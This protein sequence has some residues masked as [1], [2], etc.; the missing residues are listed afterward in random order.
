M[1]WRN[2]RQFYSEFKKTVVAGIINSAACTN[3]AT[4]ISAQILT[5]AGHQPNFNNASDA[6]SQNGLGY[7]ASLDTAKAKDS[8]RSAMGSYYCATCSSYAKLW[9][10]QLAPC[11]YSPDVLN[12][13]IIP[14]LIQVCIKGSDAA[15]P[16]GATS[17]SPD[18]VYIYKSFT[19]VI[20]NYNHAN[21]ITDALHCRLS[22]H[23]TA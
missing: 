11:K 13:V 23:T 3:G 2:F 14:R 17:I 22:Y 18:S 19:E 7:M 10:Q 6:L 15:H 21:G 20:N 12:N 1:S 9:V 16:I 4:K 8:A 5:A